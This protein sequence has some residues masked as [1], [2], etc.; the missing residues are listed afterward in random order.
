MGISLLLDERWNFMTKMK[1]VVTTPKQQILTY[2]VDDWE[3]NNGVVFFDDRS[4]TKKG[5]PVNW[6]EFTEVVK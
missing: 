6:C 4:G 3:I 1:I 2:I 5:F